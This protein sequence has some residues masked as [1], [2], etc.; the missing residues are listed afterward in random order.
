MSEI[1]LWLSLAVVMYFAGRY[2]VIREL[3]TK[4]FYL[5]YTGPHSI[6]LTRRAHVKEKP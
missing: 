1:F 5:E 2:D 3:E 6:R 4:E